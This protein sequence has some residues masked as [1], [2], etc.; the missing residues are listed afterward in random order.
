MHIDAKRWRRWILAQKFEVEE[1]K[2]QPNITENEFNESRRKY[3][4]YLTELESQLG[5]QDD[6][7][8]LDVG[9]NATCVSGIIKKGS[10]YGIDPLADELNLQERVPNF[11]IKNASGEEIPYQ[12]ETFDL[13]VCINVIDH[14][15]DPKKVMEE[16]KRVIVKDGYLIIS[17]Y[18][19]NRFICLMRIIA[20]QIPGLRNIGHPHTFSQ[21]GF[22]RLVDE[23]FD[24]VSRK[25]IYEGKTPLDFGKTQ[26]VGDRLMPFQALVSFINSKVL[27]YKWF[28]RK[29]C[30]VAKR[31]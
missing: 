10:H 21:K 5:V 31:K 3:G 2:N 11:E 4:T 23:H 15:R 17:V 22:E 20:E 18:T 28:V 24:I 1:W 27:G 14:T 25:I 16:I 9:C 13:V 7:K 6:W 30:L 12:T 29:Y 26:D 19:Y 8:I